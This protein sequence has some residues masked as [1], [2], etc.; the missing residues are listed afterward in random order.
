MSCKYNTPLM[1]LEDVIKH[2]KAANGQ[3]I[4][5]EKATKG[6]PDVGAT[7]SPVDFLIGEAR[8]YIDQAM[9][10]I[11]PLLERDELQE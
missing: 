5:V 4:I 7:K 1:R 3:L 6:I 10:Y 2:L 11:V 8:K 9:Q